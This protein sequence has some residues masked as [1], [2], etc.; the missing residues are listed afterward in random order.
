MNVFDSN[1][2]FASDFPNLYVFIINVSSSPSKQNSKEVLI[3]RLLTNEACL[4]KL[5]R[6]EE[7]YSY[8]SNYMSYYYSAFLG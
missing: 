2:I 8:S 6:M 3:A 1:S 5:K 4:W 7:V